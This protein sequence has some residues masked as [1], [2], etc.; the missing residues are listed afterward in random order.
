MPRFKISDNHFY[1]ESIFALLDKQG[2]VAS[3]AWN[4]LKVMT[5]NPK[6]YKKVLKLD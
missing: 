2:E 3:N 4:L 6:L 1:F 5:T